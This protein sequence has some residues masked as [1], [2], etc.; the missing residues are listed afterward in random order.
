MALRDT[1]SPSLTDAKKQRKR[2]EKDA[3]LLNNRIQL[4]QIEEQRTWKKIEEMK[5]RQ[6]TMEEIRRKHEEAVKLKLDSE[7]RKEEI[8]QENNHKI[9]KLKEAIENEKKKK[10]ETIQEYKKRAHDEVREI[11]DRSMR[12]KYQMYTD[13]VKQN[14]K[15]SNSVK[16]EH[17]RQA[18][19]TRR[20]EK[21]R[22][23]ENRQDYLRRV[24]QEEK[25][26]KEIEEKVIEMEI[27]EMELI[28]KLQN[29]QLMQAKTLSELES[30]IKKKPM[31]A[32]N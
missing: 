1:P 7:R 9:A 29:T 4:L 18:L 10:L 32:L 24:Q 26:K 12:E 23:E 11:R 3:I 25:L 28:K 20:N 2:L 21:L 22:E 8:K 17:K 5:K 14:Q 19:R 27:Q 16:I 6:R 31:S 13:Y 30:A 15:R